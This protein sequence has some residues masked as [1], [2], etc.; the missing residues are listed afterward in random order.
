MAK[1][2][3]VAGVACWHNAKRSLL[4]RIES[5]R[6]PSFGELALSS[7]VKATLFILYGSLGPAVSDC[8][9]LYLR[10]AA[11]ARMHAGRVACICLPKR[12]VAPSGSI[13]MK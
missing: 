8:D 11:Q 9:V 5:S 12:I 13:V 6:E 7:L 4:P 1:H 3:I 2:S 10:I